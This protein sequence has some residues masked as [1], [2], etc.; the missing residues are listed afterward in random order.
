MNELY[1]VDYIFKNGVAFSSSMFY[2]ADYVLLNDRH[3]EELN[4]TEICLI[5]VDSGKEV[6][7]SGVELLNFVKAGKILLQESIGGDRSVVALSED[8]Y[9]I[10]HGVK[11]LDTVE[12]SSSLIA[13]GHSNCDNILNLVVN[14]NTRYFPKCSEGYSPTSPNLSTFLFDYAWREETSDYCL[15]FRHIELSKDAAYQDNVYDYILR[16]K[17]YVL[18]FDNNVL[19]IIRTV[20]DHR[21]NRFIKFYVNRYEYNPKVLVSLL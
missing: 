13:Q 5:G 17:N 7:I 1:R 19:G 4:L 12:L 21:P 11:Y 2:S 6:T 15:H 14:M 8:G 3:K 16:N 9:L 10:S 18:F 20:V